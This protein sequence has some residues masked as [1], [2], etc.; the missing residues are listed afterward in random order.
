MRVTMP[1]AALFALATITAVDA[2]IAAASTDHV[3]VFFTADDGFHGKALW[4]S[5]DRDSIWLGIADLG[6]ELVTAR[7]VVSLDLE[8]HTATDDQGESHDYERLLLATG[9]RPK[10]VAAWLG[11]GQRAFPIG[12]R[13]AS[14]SKLAPAAGPG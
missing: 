4:K 14:E 1:I 13:W 10:R 2:P 7:R 3:L 11:W 12:S 5:D 6:V 9:G 8:A